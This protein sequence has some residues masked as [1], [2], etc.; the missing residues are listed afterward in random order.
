MPNLSATLI[1]FGATGDLA[2]RMLF[3]SLFN[4]QQD[5]LLPDDFLIVASGR[6]DADDATIR[7]EVDAAL[8]RHIGPDRYD[9]EAAARLT[10]RIV[11]CAAEAGNAE[12]FRAIAQ[13]VKG[14]EDK[15]IAVYLST[16]PSLFART[17]QSSEKHTVATK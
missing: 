2:G 8:R 17:A 13:R 1:L 4:L 12:Q 3:P 11:Y 15:G 9:A 10:D 5:G 7:G 14:R 16:P 6:S